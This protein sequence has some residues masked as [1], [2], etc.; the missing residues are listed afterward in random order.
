MSG[1]SGGRRG[2]ALVLPVFTIGNGKTPQHVY[3]CLL[4]E[5]YVTVWW[6]LGLRGVS[7]SYL[8][9]SWV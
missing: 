2:R 3:V 7:R 5:H 8:W 1:Y 9:R 4:L 6:K